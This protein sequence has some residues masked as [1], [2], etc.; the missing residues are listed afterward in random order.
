MGGWEVA[1]PGWKGLFV[2][3]NVIR[4]FV[5]CREGTKAGNHFN[6]EK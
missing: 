4:I 3:Y 5:L 1:G 6:F 2:F